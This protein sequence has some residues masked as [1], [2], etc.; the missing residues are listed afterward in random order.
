VLF[1]SGSPKPRSTTVLR[2]TT[3]TRQARL[4]SPGCPHHVT[5]RGNRR[6]EIF[7]DSEDRLK[8]ID[9]L[10]L[11]NQ[12]YEVDIWSYVL[13]TN[14]IHLI[15]VPQTLTSL[16]SAM[17][18]CLSDYALF[19]NRRYGYVGHLWQQRFYSS[20]L[21]YEH[22]WTAVRYVEQNPLRAGIV[23]RAEHYRWSSAPFHCGVRSTDPL[24]CADSPI[25]GAIPNWSEWLNGSESTGEFDLIR[26]NTRTGRPTRLE[27]K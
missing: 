21:G 6:Q 2:L 23:N 5:Q 27:T 8:L 14:H 24:I 25:A 7:R 17:R 15:A 10:R 13:M 9:L 26:S 19:F 18:D 16:S 4:V 20:M 1:S 22:L 3:M 12:R 11:Y